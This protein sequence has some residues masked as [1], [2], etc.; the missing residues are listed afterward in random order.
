MK[1]VTGFYKDIVLL[2]KIKS[3]ELKKLPLG[4]L[5]YLRSTF[6][7]EKLTRIGDKYVINSFIPPFPSPAFEQFAKNAVS[8]YKQEAFPYSTHIALT[9]KC[10]FNC[11]HCSKCY[12][13]GEELS[14]DIWLQVVKK[15]QNMGICIIGFT[16]GEPLSNNN[17]EEIITAIDDRSTAI[18]FTSGHGLTDKRAK[19]LKSAG[20]Y[21]IAISL[22]HYTE[23]KHNKLRGRADAFDI[24]IKAIDTSLKNNFYTAVQLV[25]RKDMLNTEEMD[26][27]IDFVTK[28][29]V[30]EIRIIEP[31][32]T[33][34]LIK[35]KGD[36]FLKEPERE[37]L[38]G[39]H[40]KTNK[41]NN[42]T[43]IASFTYLE[44]KN[45]YG[46]GAGVQHMYIDAFGNVCPCDFTPLSFG[47]IKKDGFDIAYKR[48]R[49]HFDKP[50]ATCFIQ[51][52]IEKIR[53]FFSNNLPLKYAA[54]VQICN[55]CR[56]RELPRFY[57]KLGW[58]E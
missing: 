36:I 54:S 2:I 16:G 42:L 25:V 15:L 11:W 21:Y 3:R 38:R 7:N 50:R 23:E 47:N 34:V 39:Y 43:K 24:A 5:L 29:G 45:M 58:K 55:S 53:P 13:E 56:K 20:L 9:N 33:G 18:L 37:F 1:H 22:D 41:K 4:V 19:S 30:H 12:R 57:K 44:N 49:A 48:L 14:K 17:L 26:R 27:Y 51:D 32:P 52:N 10:S 31:M 40:I 8:V 46:C 28:L 35:E 6:R